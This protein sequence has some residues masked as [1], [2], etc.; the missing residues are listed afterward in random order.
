MNKKAK[1]ILSVVI[2]LALGITASTVIYNEI[3]YNK[4]EYILYTTVDNHDVTLSVPKGSK[5]IGEQGLGGFKFKTRNT[6]EEVESFYKSYLDS[7]PTVIYKSGKRTAHYDES[8]NI[9]ICDLSFQT[10][11]G[12]LFFVVECECM[13]PGKP[14]SDWTLN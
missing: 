13:I 1:I 7:L 5:F 9:V 6:Q 8:R 11:K 2:L 4:S 12:A 14:N 3:Q 10:S